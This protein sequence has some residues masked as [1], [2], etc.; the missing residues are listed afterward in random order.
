MGSDHAGGSFF[1]LNEK[2]GPRL[3]L[4]VFIMYIQHIYIKLTGDHLISSKMY[5]FFFLKTCYPST[6]PHLDGGKSVDP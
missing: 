4:Y 1:T 2:K 3:C 6:K 5:L